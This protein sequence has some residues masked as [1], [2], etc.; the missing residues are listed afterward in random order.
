MDIGHVTRL[1][2]DPALFNFPST[3]GNGS[4]TLNMVRS[5][6]CFLLLSAC[7]LMD[8]LKLA[9]VDATERDVIAY[10]T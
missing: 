5:F 4:E 8:A 10:N 3:P 2:E 1:D 9:R 7:F 6:I